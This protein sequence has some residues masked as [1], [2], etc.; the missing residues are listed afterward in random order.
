MSIRERTYWLSGAARLRRKD[1]SLVFELADGNR[2]PVPVTDIADIITTAPV[3]I[4]TA[5]MALLR[6]H[7]IAVHVLDHYGNYAG[8]VAPASDH[9][10]GEIVRKQVL[11]AEDPKRRNV[12]ARAFVVATAFNVRWVLGREQLD[13]SYNRFVE[14]VG[15]TESPAEL[16]AAEGNFRRSCWALLDTKLP[17]WLCLH[18]RSR[19]PPANPANAFVSFVNSLIYSR[20]LTAIRLT[21]LHPGI[22]FLH[23]TMARRRFTLALDL[24]EHFKPIFAE[25]LLLRSAHQRSLTLA[26]F[27]CEANASLLSEAGRKKV[28]AMVRDELDSTVYHRGLKRKVRYEEL[29]HLEALKLV[30]TFLEDQPFKPFKVWW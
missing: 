22:G 27:D 23:T 7:E 10:S 19:R 8:M 20:A 4:N 29:F 16:M 1:D 26:D 5:T 13:S 3:D 14:A 12:I 9:C 25:R 30:R 28:L 18:G 24:A 2:V 15:R 21:P 11:A 6:Q 17:D